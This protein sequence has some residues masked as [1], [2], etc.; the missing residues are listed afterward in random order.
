MEYS[1]ELDC[2]PLM[3]RPSDYIAGVIKGTVLE[4][5]PELEPEN[6]VSRCFGNWEWHYELD[7]EEYEKV[8]PILKE[9]ITA[10]YNA[11]FIRYGS[12]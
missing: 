4:G 11:G 2:P 5:K 7:E 1:I 8:M 6:T 10:L 9:R 12:W 3:P